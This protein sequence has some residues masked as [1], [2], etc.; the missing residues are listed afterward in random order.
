MI[1]AG[2]TFGLTEAECERIDRVDQLVAIGAAAVDEL[3]VALSER[4]WTVRR[5]VVAGLAAL[6]DDAARPLCSWLLEQRTT[7]AAI[8]GAVDALSTSIGVT[9][10]A[11][12]IAIGARGTGAVLEDVARILGRRRAF[13]GVAVLRALLGDPN[14]NIAMAA[15]E[16]LGAIGGTAS[17]DALISVIESRNFFRTFPAMQVAARSGDPRVIEP[18]A[19]LLDDESYRFE[20]ALALGRTGSVLAIAPLAGLLERAGGLTA[21]LVVSA[22][23][24]LWRRAAWSGAV[25]H[26]LELMRQRFASAVPRFVVAL[27]GGELAERL[28]A[29]RILGGIGGA[30][31]LSLLAPLLED[32]ELRAAATEAVQRVV[33]MDDAALL[34]AIASPDPETRAAALPVVGSAR[35]APAVRRLLAD[36]EPEVRARACDA[37]ARIGDTSSV[38]VLFAALDDASPR[39]SHAAAAAIHS[40]GSTETPGLALTALRSSRPN[41]RRQALRI[42]AYLGCDGAFEA[43]RAAIDDPDTRIG[44]LAVGALAALSDPGVDHVLAEVACSPR[45][46]LRAA[47][48]RA[49]GHRSGDRMV[50]LLDRGVDDDAAWVR[51][52]A[53]QGLGRAGRLSA[54]NKLMARLADASAH[55]RVAAIEALARLDTPQAWQMLMSLARSADPDEQRAALVGLGQ[56][57]QPAAVALLVDAASSPDI[58]TRLIS[59]AGLSGSKVPAARAVL[60]RAAG[61]PQPEIRDAALSL[62]GERADVDAAALLV[63]IALQCAP[64]HPVH[65]TLSRPGDARIAEIRARLDTAKEGEVGILVSALARMHVPEATRA[66][67]DALVAP[68]PEVRRDAA[69]ALMAIGAAGSAAAVKKLAMEDPDP[70]VRRASIAALAG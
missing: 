36:E 26:V 9:T 54:A 10:T 43:V 60:A 44:E 68:S 32:P 55:V 70:E 8:A 27:T 17:I 37:L 53:C 4:S 6:G 57:S 40:L 24:E 14:D 38:R 49:A 15:I 67:F 52:Y 34:K 46:V 39:V 23:D 3:L 58:A 19:A 11:E 50:D 56:H 47:V 28:A 25:D 12:V 33:R 42:I 35:S 30:E 2:S 31:T 20:A 63:D 13:E 16:A 66:L 22:L 48:M 59:L 65:A 1:A 29:I 5:A 41:V 64:E 21:R 61:D 45:E 69:T 7:E 18:L 51:Y 62:L